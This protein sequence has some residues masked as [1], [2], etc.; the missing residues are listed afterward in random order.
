MRGVVDEDVEL[1]VGAL[2]ELDRARPVGSLLTS[3]CDEQRRAAGLVDLG[4]DL[5]AELVADVAEHDARAL[6][7]EQPRLGLALPA[8]GARDQRDLAVEPSHQ[9]ASPP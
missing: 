8:R 3:R 5:L 6:L 2:G 4:G 9:P 7:R 1:A